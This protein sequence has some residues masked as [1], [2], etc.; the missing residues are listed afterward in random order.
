MLLF[1]MGFFRSCGNLLVNQQLYQAVIVTTRLNINDSVP[2]VNFSVVTTT[3]SYFS[4]FY[5][6]TLN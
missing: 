6:H 5:N 1:Y 3:P 2:T 4:V